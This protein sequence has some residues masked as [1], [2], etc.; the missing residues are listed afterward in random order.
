MKF[1]RIRILWPQRIAAV[2]LLLFFAQCL[3]VIGRTPLSETDYRYALCG[4]E[5]WERPSAIAGY[6]T[7]CGNM[8]GDGTLAYR[9]AGA[10]MSANILLLRVQDAVH[11]RFDKNYIANPLSGATHDLRHQ[12]KGIPYLLRVPFALFAVWIGGG[13]WWVS[14]RLFGN[15]GGFFALGL[16][17]FSPLVVRYA[18]M[19]NNEILALWGLYG[20]IYTAIGIAHAM[21]GPRRKW[22]PRILLFTFALG[23]TAAAHIA[24]AV[25]GLI[26]SAVFMLYVAE[27]R[28]SNVAPILLMSSCGALVILLA[29]FGFRLHTF[30]YAFT[31]G[32]GLITSSTENARRLFTNPLEFPAWMALAVAIVLYVAVR[33][34]RYFGNT[35][36]LLIALAL[37]FWTTT[38]VASA[39]WL[40][41]L[42]FLFTFTAGVF[43]DAL[44]TRSRKLY[45]ALSGCVLLAQAVLCWTSL[46]RLHG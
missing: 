4:R 16:F 2:L 40:W 42:P 43:A 3:Y 28:R 18:T 36:P 14:R 15:L 13:V 7:S 31:A 24:A 20:L 6:F 34:S 33:R 30:L 1:P 46:P 10:P 12:I 8:Q 17:C 37:L 19:P 35:T 44:E 27:R 22:R 23:M 21:Y 38:Q 25:F 41:S 39:P 26:V 11:R 9:V 29:S 5:M 45:L 32:A